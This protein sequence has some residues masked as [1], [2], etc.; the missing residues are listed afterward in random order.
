MQTFTLNNGVQIPVLGFGVF[1]IP[2]A[3]TAQAVA[4]AIK[5]GYR[6][7]DTA[8]AYMNEAE[9]GQGVKQSGV[10]R[11]EIFITSKVWV[12]NY[13]Y[14]A[15][16]GSLD[17]TLSRLDC[18]HIDLMLLHQPFNDIY[19]AWRALEEYGRQNPRYR[20]EQLH[21]RPCHRPWHLQQSHACRRPD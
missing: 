19:G 9:V 14:E 13:G 16:K 8:Q 15:A 5:A 18:G 6:H 1:Q 4:E 3:E 12:E 17:R 2:P 21:R 7:I 10:A 11:E 20:R